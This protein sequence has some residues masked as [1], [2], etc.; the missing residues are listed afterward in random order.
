MGKNKRQVNANLNSIKY[1]FSRYYLLY[2]TAWPMRLIRAIVCGTTQQKRRTASKCLTLA[3]KSAGLRLTAT[4][5]K[6]MAV[7]F[8][9]KV[10][11]SRFYV[12]CGSAWASCAVCARYRLWNRLEKGS[13]GVAIL[14]F[15]CSKRWASVKLTMTS[16]RDNSTY[17]FSPLKSHH[18][19]GSFKPKFVVLPLRWLKYWQISMTMCLRNSVFPCLLACGSL[20]SCL[21]LVY[22]W[23]SSRNKHGIFPVQAL[24]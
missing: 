6:I 13:S 23:S 11:I 9:R 24:L 22:L 18:W 1:V 4:S 14:D 17:I 8:Y 19:C 16:L 21:V 2:K 7:V 20:I 10:Y 15:C 3:V 5:W 12:L